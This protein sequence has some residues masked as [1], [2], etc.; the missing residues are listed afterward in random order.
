M[1][2][3]DV[4]DEVRRLRFDLDLLRV[5][6]LVTVLVEHPLV[7]DSDRNGDRACAFRP[8]ADPHGDDLAY[9]DL[10]DWGDA[11]RLAVPGELDLDAPP[12]ELPALL[13][14][15]DVLLPLPSLEARGR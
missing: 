5:A 12:R 15:A 14:L 4:L 2:Q 7:R 13:D 1:D 11:L 3:K 6:D 9:A 8:H 10:R